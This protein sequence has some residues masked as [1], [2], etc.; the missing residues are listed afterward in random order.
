MVLPEPK[1]LQTAITW[2]VSG[3]MREQKDYQR[4]GCKVARRMFRILRSKL[5]DVLVIEP[6]KLVA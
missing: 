1:Q 6:G 4:C 3:R 5:M 2:I